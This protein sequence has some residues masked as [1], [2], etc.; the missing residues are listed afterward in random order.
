MKD[1]DGKGSGQARRPRSALP[2]FQVIVLVSIASASK[3]PRPVVSL[4]RSSLLSILPSISCIGR[5][6]MHVSAAWL[7]THAV[8]RASLY[9]CRAWPYLNAPSLHLDMC[10]PLLT[11]PCLQGS[12]GGP[13]EQ[14]V[15]GLVV[16]STATE[17]AKGS[18]LA[19]DAGVHL[20][21]ITRILAEH[22]PSKTLHAQSLPSNS[23]VE[24]STK[25]RSSRLSNGT[26]SKVRSSHSPRGRGSH[27]SRETPP[28]SAASSKK[29]KSSLSQGP[30]AGLELPFDSASANA[31][32]I[33]RELVSTY[34]ITHPHLDHIS[35]FVVN[36]ASFQHTSRPKRLAALPSTIDAIKSHIFNDVIW[37][38]LSDEEGGVG[39]VSYMRLAEGGNVA[40]G[41]GDGRGYIEVC[42][43]LGVKSWIVSHGHCM[44][45][46]SH[47]GAGLA[48]LDMANHSATASRRVSTQSMGSDQRRSLSGHLSDRACVYDSTAFFIRDDHSGKEVLIFGDVEPDTISLLPRTSQVWTEAASKIAAGLLTGIFIECSYDDSQS[49]ETLFGHLAPRHLM[50]ELK[51]LAGA[52]ARVQASQTASQRKRKRESNGFRKDAGAIDDANVSRRR[53]KSAHRPAHREPPDVLPAMARTKSELAEPGPHY[54][55]VGSDLASSTASTRSLPLQ[56]VRIII[57][58]MKDTLR[59]GPP[60]G[61]PILA[62][63]QAYEE[64]ARLGCEFVISQAGSSVWL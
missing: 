45:K 37:P 2:A 12:G 18:L 32:F 10:N 23:T 4:H 57:I 38:N 28:G 44:K 34:L 35:G 24:K 59:D 46:H 30:F 13:N 51:F 9:Q 56:G 50:E 5:S 16:R 3:G 43:G 48:S 33:T 1:D 62:Q 40:I 58:H 15:T 31:A 53:T 49:D 60:I 39:L 14:N 29:S 52:V 47:G 63:L 22:M 54:E 7:L 8:R 17:W 55:S 11:F 20:A 41:E 26:E 42:D 64:T 6:R 21:A 27:D 19:V 61:E 36:T 25:T